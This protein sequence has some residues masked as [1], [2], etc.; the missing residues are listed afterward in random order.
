MRT[1]VCQ[2]CGEPADPDA[3]FCLRCGAFLEWSSLEGADDTR[4]EPAVR[5]ADQGVSGGMASATAVVPPE[6]RTAPPEPEGLAPDVLLPPVPVQRPAAE[7]AAVRPVTEPIG[8]VGATD[9]CPRCGTANPPEL[10][11]CGKCAAELGRAPAPT[12]WQAG[13]QRRLPWW[14]RLLT[15]G[16]SPSESK[17]LRA[18]RRSLPMRYRVIRAIA[19]LLVLVLVALAVWAIRGNPISWAKARWYDLRDTVQPVAVS[20]ATLDPAEAQVRVEFE[21]Q[22]AVDGDPASAWA[23]AW[24]AGAQPAGCSGEHATAEALVLRFDEVADVRKLRVAAGLPAD[25]PGR[26]AQ[27]RPRLLEVRSSDGTCQTLPLADRASEQ[28]LELTKPV[29]TDLLR[30]DVLDVYAPESAGSDL[31]AVS[32]VVPLRR[33]PH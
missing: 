22:A 18:Y 23:T 17:A 7:S 9:R 25:D 27:N 6:T 8:A 14:R 3:E 19:G 16:R 31:V 28:T 21:P 2:E 20:G 12:G 4:Q 1:T 11:F 5:A 24:T 15:R 32:E 30:I 10:R 13:P 29:S 26:L 33:P